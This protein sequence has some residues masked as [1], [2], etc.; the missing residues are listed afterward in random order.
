MQLL[1][2]LL[3]LV[4]LI[5]VLT[6]CATR[7]PVAN[8]PASNAAIEAFALKGRVGVNVDGRGYSASVQWRHV[9]DRDSMRLLV[10]AVGSVIAEIEV[11]R[12]GATL[13][14]GDKKVYKSSDVQSLTREVLGW[15]LPLSGLRF[16]VTGRA[17]P[18]FPLQS[19]SRDAK[20]RYA[21]FVQNE[22]HVEY[23][24]YFGDSALP[25]RLSLVRDQLRLRLVV[26]TWD[27]AP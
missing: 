3:A 4:F 9:S 16:W 18:G 25:S 21:A 27:L 14:T 8:L 6:G 7:Q 23:L 5:A 15:D 22:W 10:P 1:H 26:E 2:R 19:E 17:D 20:N 12:N 11:D 13:T 24:D